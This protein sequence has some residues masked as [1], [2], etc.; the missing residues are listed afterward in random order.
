MADEYNE[1]YVLAGGHEEHVEIFPEYIYLTIP[2]AWVCVYHKLLSYIADFGKTIVDDCTAV[3]KG[4][5][6][7]ILNCWNIFQS[8]VACN[9]LGRTKEAEFFIEYIK[10]QLTNVYRGTDATVYCGEVP[11]AVT[12][13]GTLKAVVSCKND[14]HFYV[15]AETGELYQSYLENQQEGKV[16]TIKDDD[17]TAE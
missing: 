17:L 10:K 13:N 12:E 5:G 15:D 16:Y 8:A 14:I 7:N 1:L 4:N 3:C 11:V 9:A 2:S 6:K